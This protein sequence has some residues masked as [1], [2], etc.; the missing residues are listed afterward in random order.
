MIA[1]RHPWKQIRPLTQQESD[2]P[3]KISGIFRGGRASIRFLWRQELNFE[4]VRKS[5]SMPDQALA[6]RAK[7]ETF[8]AP[9]FQSKNLCRAYIG[10]EPFLESVLDVTSEYTWIPRLVVRQNLE[11][12]G[13]VVLRIVYIFVLPALQDGNRVMVFWRTRTRRR[14]IPF[15]LLETRHTLERKHSSRKMRIRKAVKYA[16]DGDS[17]FLSTA[18]GIFSL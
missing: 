6:P 10:V 5:V 1:H 2:P 17:G 11:S 16:T 12:K 8:F 4:I 18:R 9:N 13:C 15:H 7:R 3:C 14:S